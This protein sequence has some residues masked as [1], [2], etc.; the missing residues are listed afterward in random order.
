MKNFDLAIKIDPVAAEK[1][2]L[3][4]SQEAAQLAIFNQ[5]ELAFPRAR[6][7]SRLAP[8]NDKVWF[9]LGVLQLET[10]NYDAA[11]ASLNRARTINSRNAHVLL[12]LGLANFIQKKYQAAIEHY[13]AS[14]K[15]KPDDLSGLLELGNTYYMIGRLPDAIAQYNKAV[16]QNPT[17]WPAIRNIGLIK[18]EQGKLEEA[19]QQWQTAVSLEK[20]NSYYSFNIERL[21]DSAREYKRAKTQL[22]A[23]AVALYTKGD[24]E[25]GLTLGKQ[26]VSIDKRYGN[27]EFLKENLWGDRLLKDTQKFL[28]YLQVQ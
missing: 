10:K 2:G 14:L 3:S 26:A 23:L 6:L 16:A 28:Q 24:R 11:I 8:R 5:F 17:F 4:L 7:A 18:Y 15:L 20:S 27:I 25:Q 21:Y 22:L 13:Q 12:E 1:R 19:I 9:M